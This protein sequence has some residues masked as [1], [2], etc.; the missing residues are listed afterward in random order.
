LSIRLDSLGAT[1]PSV[2]NNLISPAIL[3]IK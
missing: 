2:E 1:H 3:Y